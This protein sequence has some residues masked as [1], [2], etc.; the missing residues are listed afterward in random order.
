MFLSSINS[1]NKFS[2][3]EIYCTFFVKW[4]IFSNVKHEA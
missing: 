1:C 2:D 3:I 4:E